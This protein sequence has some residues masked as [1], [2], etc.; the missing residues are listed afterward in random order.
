MRKFLTKCR[1]MSRDL[2]FSESGIDEDLRAKGSDGVK[3][4]VKDGGEGAAGT[5]RA[6]V[7][8]GR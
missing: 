6:R 4:L 8:R 2:L 1:L 3:A 5:T 7:D